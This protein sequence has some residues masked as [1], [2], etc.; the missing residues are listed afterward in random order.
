MEEQ[1]WDWWFES[2][3]KSAFF[4]HDFGELNNSDGPDILNCELEVSGKL[5][6]GAVEFDYNASGW[7]EHGHFQNYRF[8][9]ILLHVYALGK[10]PLYHGNCP[11]FSYCV[12]TDRMQNLS[13]RRD[14]FA[15]RKTDFLSYYKQ[16]FTWD[17]LLFLLFCRTLGYYHNRE[18]MTYIAYALLTRTHE[19]F[20]AQIGDILRQA[21]KRA[22]R[23]N[24]RI[25]IRI[26]QASRLYE[27]SF[28]IAEC[29]A[30]FRARLA[31][32]KLVK[33]LHELFNR[34]MV[35]LPKIGRD[36]II[37]FLFNWAL[38][39][40]AARHLPRGNDSY[41]QYLSDVFEQLKSYAAIRSI[42]SES[43]LEMTLDDLIS[44]YEETL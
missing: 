9:S 43:D 39:M 38:P 26:Q 2:P 44:P 21:K 22:V 34:N 6:R 33:A 35:E 42:H 28:W 1:L 20:A 12:N 8:E 13:E 17:D 29:F 24:N 25:N 41:V 18:L 11:R 4:I 7:V 40:E 10:L 27:N 32:K 37:L 19:Q 30:L 14:G 15:T 36:R 16:I 31:A 5:Y 23:P 3:Q